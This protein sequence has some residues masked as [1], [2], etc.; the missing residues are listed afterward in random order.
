MSGYFELFPNT[1][2]DDTR[3]KDI[4]RRIAVRRSISADPRAYA[5]YEVPAGERADQVAEGYY[6]RAEREWLI[7]HSIDL[8]DPYYDWYLSDEN[9]A[10]LIL[11][12]YGTLEEA[13]ERIHHWEIDWYG[14]TG[15]I[16]VAQYSLLDDTFKK[17]YEPLFG[18]GSEILSYIRR[19]D[20]VWCTT[21]M[22]VTIGVGT[23]NGFVA[24]ERL[25]FYDGG[26][27]EGSAELSWSNTTH[28]KI[29]HVQTGA[30]TGYT[31]V[32]ANS[33]VSK[34]ITSR[35]YTAN[36]IPIDERVYWTPV[37]AIDYERDKNERKKNVRL[38]DSRHVGQIEIESRRLLA[39]T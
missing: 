7:W 25:Q 21:N 20:D 6:G 22:I 18:S 2:Y 12:K 27:L 29:V 1:V 36:V 31:V 35:E 4:T 3:C 24:G 39:N 37:T 8:I 14:E 5:P 30:N 34:T 16:S 32:G 19:E 28:L 33:G 10:E 38:I 13:V 15:E 26:T 23:S 11:Q 17:Y 9:F